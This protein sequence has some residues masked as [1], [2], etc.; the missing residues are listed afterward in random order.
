[1]GLN[2]VTEVS[3]IRGIQTQTHR[4]QGHAR[5]DRDD[6]DAGLSQGR[7]R[8]AS[9]H[10]E[11]EEASQARFFSRALGGS[12]PLLTPWFQTS[13]LQN[14]ARINF[15]VFGHPMCGTLL[16]QLGLLKTSYYILIF[17]SMEVF[18]KKLKL[19]GSFPR[20]IVLVITMNKK[21]MLYIL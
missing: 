20:Q 2:P 7:P 14:Y 15:F 21:D 11:L 4:R 19:T 1:M 6:S 16:H 10:Q 17:I 3:L 8:T 18:M 9:N 5:E 13:N 12:M